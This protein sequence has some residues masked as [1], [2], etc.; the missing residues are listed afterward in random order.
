M[1][2]PGLEIRSSEVAV[3]RKLGQIQGHHY[4]STIAQQLGM[5]REK[6]AR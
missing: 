1:R 5:A 2:D 4:V 6:T 3:R